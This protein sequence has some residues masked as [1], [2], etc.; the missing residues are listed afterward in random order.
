MIKLSAFV[1]V[2]VALAA[3]GGCKKKSDAPG[4]GPTPAPTPTPAPAPAP[5]EPPAAPP[6]DQAAVRAV[7]DAWLAAQNSGDQAAYGALYAAKM[8]GVKRVGDRT[9]RF[10]RA[11]WLADR[12]RMFKKP[13]TVAAKDVVIAGS[14]AVP[15]VELVQTFTQ[16]TFSDE[17]PKRMVLVRDGAGAYKIAR[18]EMLASVVGGQRPAGAAA[19]PFLVVDVDGHAQ[20]VLATDADPSWGTGPLT[21]PFE[22]TH[23]YALRAA[24]K[25]PDAAAWQARTLAVYDAD[26]Q[27]CDA[28]VGALHLLG[29]G[30]PHFGTV[31]EW[32]DAGVTPADRAAQIYAMGPLYLVG[33]L[34]VTGACKPVYAVDAGRQVTAFAPTPVDGAAAAPAVTA[35]RKLP[36]YAAIQR[37]YASDP[38]NQGAWATPTVTAYAAG[39]RRYLVVRAQVGNG[40]GEFSGA[41]TAVF[42]DRGG[43]LTLIDTAGDLQVTA[44]LDSGTAGQLELIGAPGDFSTVTAHYQQTASGLGTDREVAF[45]FNDCGC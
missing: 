3:A 10:D 33:E 23:R 4:P 41:V 40:C 26:G 42:A 34:A 38:A 14:V 5:T 28:T 7:V 29:G 25:A 9:W 24:T 27:R 16:G 11:G 39:D 37:D 43:Q 15:T 36:E 19:A 8:E 30:T 1:C 22:G 32:D 20:V 45:P 44:A 6:V 18:E 31:Q 13:M 17:G 35:F 12:A 21:G 2:A